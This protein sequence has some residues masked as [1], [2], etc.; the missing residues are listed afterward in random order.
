MSPVRQEED[1]DDEGGSGFDLAASSLAGFGA[2]LR[3]AATEALRSRLVV[4]V[5]LTIA[6]ALGALAWGAGGDGTP[7]GHL[8]AF[9]SWGTGWVELVLSLTTVF[10]STTL[11]QALRDGRLVVVTAGPL[12]RGLLPAGWWAGT[13]VALA[14]LVVGAQTTVWALARALERRAPPASAASSARMARI[15]D[16]RGVARPPVADTSGVVAARVD[17]TLAAMERAGE[18]TDRTPE[19]REE[20]RTWLELAESERTRTVP[21]GVVKEWT[22]DGIAP[23]PGAETVTLRFRY[24]ARD[25][26]GVHQ[27]PTRGPRGLWAIIPP[28]SPG[29]QLAGRWTGSAT[30]EVEAPI[31]VLE[32]S[33]SVTLWYQ[34]R[35]ENAVVIVFPEQA[36]ELLYPAGSFEGN[37][38]RAGAVL[39]GRL[40]ILAAV[41]VAAAALIDGKLAALAALFVLAVGAGR[42]FLLESLDQFHGFGA[43][44]PAVVAALQGLLWLLPDM[45]SADIAGLLSA[46]EQVEGAHVLRSLGLDGVLRAGGLLALAAVLFERRELGA[47]Q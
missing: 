37:V 10:L 33:S 24:S 12:P 13:A 7:E 31:E 9:L 47:V 42:G 11:A 45:A 4:V 19:Q 34:N 32:G 27:V 22:V 46:G 18:L 26:V 40:L 8:R 1:D 39:L 21:R 5:G 16:A 30:H 2:I 6:L 14:L 3:I 36:V 23:A 15:L 43:A 25:A 29:T 20:V 28:D 17:E 41:G 38:A 44:S 35:E